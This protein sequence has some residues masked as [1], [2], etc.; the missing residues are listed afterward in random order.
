MHTSTK[1]AKRLF[2]SDFQ[3]KIEILKALNIPFEA[4]IKNEELGF[5]EKFLSENSNLKVV[6]NHLGNPKIHRLSEYK[7]N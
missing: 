1:G 4:C 2:D 6:L 7:K 3:E 5:L